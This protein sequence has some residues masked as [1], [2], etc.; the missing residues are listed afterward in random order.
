MG[1]GEERAIGGGEFAE[2][3]WRLLLE[4]GPK[5]GVL[6]V[7]RL[8]DQHGV[9]G[10]ELV[11]GHFLELIPA[12]PDRVLVVDLR[13]QRPLPA[14][15]HRRVEV[16]AFG[17]LRVVELRFLGRTKHE[18]QVIGNLGRTKG[19]FATAVHEIV[20]LLLAGREFG[21]KF[22]GLLGAREGLDRRELLGLL[23]RVEDR[24]ERVIF[25]RRHWVELVVVAAGA[26]HREALGATH[27]DIDAVV[28]DVRG[29]V[30][31]AASEGQEA[32]RG[33]VTVVFG[34]LGDLVCGDLQ[35]QELVVG[36]IVVEG[37]HHPV[38]IGVGVRV[39]SFFLEDVP[40]G[41]GV[42]GDIQPVS[43]PALAESRRSQQAVDELL[44]RLRIFVGHVRCD[45]LGGRV[46]SPE[47]ERETTDDDL[48][49]RL[50]IEVE[51]GGFQF[52]EDE[53]VQR[54][55]NLGFVGRSEDGRHRSRDDLEGPMVTSVMGDG[56]SLARPG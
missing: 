10:G 13:L 7:F 21:F 32:E 25:G 52:R 24:V 12:T 23:A 15:E 44:G 6:E 45:L 36:S 31:E 51:A 41:V 50:G 48:A 37:V 22:V 17:F 38:A 35:T 40:F 46:E 1:F 30:E 18:R 4:L 3:L 16:G 9:L 43:C 28:D 8:G 49:G 34:V 27:D 29:A 14:I 53:T 54:L 47:R 20:E 42:A 33:E 56:R 2:F 5:Q 11:V 39:A 19:E 26:G 55:A